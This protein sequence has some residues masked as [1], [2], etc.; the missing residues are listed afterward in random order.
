MLQWAWHGVAAVVGLGL[1]AGVSAAAPSPGELPAHVTQPILTPPPP[2]PVEVRRVDP[3]EFAAPVETERAPAARP[4]K[5]V[6]KPAR[7]TKAGRSGVKATKHSSAGTK[8]ARGR[9]QAAVKGAQAKK[10]H[11]RSQL[12]GK[13][14]A[15]PGK[16]AKQIKGGKGSKAIKGGKGAKGGKA[17]KSTVS[18]RGSAKRAKTAGAGKKGATAARGRLTPG[19]GKSVDLGNPGG[20]Y[21]PSGSGGAEA[22]AP[23]VPAAIGHE[24]EPLDDG[25]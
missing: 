18:T 13:K 10:S 5:A 15:R 2:Q 21:A 6:T 17:G 22:A 11:P 14:P 3:A 25:R 16:G 23:A 24:A 7:P 19:G 12:K 8:S 4:S 1:L 9:A 20:K